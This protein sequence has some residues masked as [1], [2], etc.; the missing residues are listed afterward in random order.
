MRNNKDNN[1]RNNN[2][3]NRRITCAKLNATI[4]ILSLS[5]IRWTQFD[6]CNSIP[7]MIKYDDSI[8]PTMII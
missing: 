4:T 7:M 3:N 1:K 8:K 2:N 5:S 6:D